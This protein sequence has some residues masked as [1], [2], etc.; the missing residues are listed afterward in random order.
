M[1]V[2]VAESDQPGLVKSIIDFI[3]SS[4]LSPLN[5][6]WDKQAVENIFEEERS[7]DMIKVTTDH[8]HRE[9]V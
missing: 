8:I 1:Y 6:E 9:Q 4:P 2:F 5:T 7:F 3:I